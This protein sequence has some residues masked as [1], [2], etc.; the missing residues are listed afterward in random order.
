[1][2]GKKTKNSAQIDNTV[3]KSVN[4]EVSIADL[5]RRSEKRAW[6]VA[7]AS[8]LMSLI[9]AGGYFYMLPLKEKVPYMVMAD[10]YTG[11][12]TVATLRGDFSK[13]SITSS[14]AINRSNVARYVSTRESFDSAMMNLGDWKL[15]HVMSSP[16]V[17]A[18]YSAIHAPN[19]PDAPFKTYG[20][21]RA[22]R[23]NIL[24]IQLNSQSSAA[25]KD[26][27]RRSATVRFQRSVYDKKTGASKLLDNKIANLE[28]SYNPNLEMDEK[29]RIMNPLGFQ[30]LEYRVD[31][32]YSGASP[33]G[34]PGDP[35]ST[36]QQPAGQ[37]A[38]GQPAY[39]QPGYGQPGYGQPAYGQP[40]YGQPVPGQPGQ[41]GYGQPV[42]GQPVQG[43]PYPAPAPGTT[44]PVPDFG[45]PTG[46]A[47]ATQPQ[48]PAVPAG[49]VPPPAPAGTAPNQA[50]GVSSR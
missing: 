13:N 17:S 34:Q 35:A 39:G 18:G 2:L 1:M 45:S 24:S 12:A 46:T 20:R 22:V 27:Q 32:D 36:Q 31:N 21:E 29:T 49:T 4:F 5:A 11:V 41:P 50:N 33:V 48:N 30:V 38:Y 23:V 40:A 3:A 16:N 37:P 47:P 19:N 25:A 8:I 10:A 44:P 43:Q 15:V 9:L 6:M 7:F 26:G 28:Y 42:Q 14:E